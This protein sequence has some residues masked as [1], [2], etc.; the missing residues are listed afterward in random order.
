MTRQAPSGGSIAPPTGY[1][2]SADSNSPLTH[3]AAKRNE[4]SAARRWNWKL[5][6]PSA[7]VSRELAEGSSGEDRQRAFQR[8]TE[9]R[10]TNDCDREATR[11]GKIGHRKRNDLF[12]VGL[13]SPAL[14]DAE[15]RD[16]STRNQPPSVEGST[17]SALRRAGAV[18]FP[19]A[20]NPNRYQTKSVRTQVGTSSRAS[21]PAR[22]PTR[23]QCFPVWS[24]KNSAA[25]AQFSAV[26]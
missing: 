10:W 3:N 9:I 2:P 21:M 5:Q 14:G 16:H 11:M 24:S 26:S 15:R 19:P 17:A 12:A 25:N 4:C 13:D 6:S 18:C 8:P 1:S 23:N 7:E 20:F 22:C